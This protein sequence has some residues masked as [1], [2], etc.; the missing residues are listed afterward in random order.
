MKLKDYPLPVP[1]AID[2]A[3][4]TYETDARLLDMAREGG[5][6]KQQNPYYK[7]VMNVFFSGCGGFENKDG[8]PEDYRNKIY[9]YFRCLMR[10]FAPKHEHKMAVC[11]FLLSEIFEPTYIPKDEKEQ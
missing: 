6:D 1:T 2:F 5:F 10:S 3:F 8:I 4:S 11:A 9:P 7:L